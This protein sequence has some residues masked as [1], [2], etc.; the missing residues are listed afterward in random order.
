M[1]LVLAVEL[2]ALVRFVQSGVLELQLELYPSVSDTGE[3]ITVENA[4]EA[5]FFSQRVILRT[6]STAAMFY[7]PRRLNDPTLTQDGNV[8]PE[9]LL[10]PSA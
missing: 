4:E 2:W 9:M 6:A 7:T 1:V 8:Y 5:R 3:T 10:V